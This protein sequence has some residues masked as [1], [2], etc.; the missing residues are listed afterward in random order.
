M[1]MDVIALVC[2]SAA[3]VT[4]IVLLVS[5][6]RDGRRLRTALEALRGSQE[7]TV[8]LLEYFQQQDLQR[9]EL[10]S[11]IEDAEEIVGL[12]DEDTP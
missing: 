4:T 5:T 6:I 2:V 8:R 9:A 12:H 10:L 3:L 1:M 11:I 7:R